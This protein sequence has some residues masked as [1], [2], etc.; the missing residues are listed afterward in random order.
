MKRSLSSVRHSTN[1]KMKANALVEGV[2]VAMT[3]IPNNQNDRKNNYWA[4]LICGA[5]QETN[6]V[7]KYLSSKIKCC[8]YEQMVKNF[9]KKTTVELNKLK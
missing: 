2:I 5:N 4:A 7:I 9:E 3:N 8:L 6:R 1:I